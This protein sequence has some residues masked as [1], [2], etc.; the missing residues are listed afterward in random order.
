MSVSWRSYVSAHKCRSA[1]AS[2]SCATI[3]TRSPTR[4]P[5]PSRSVAT[6]S[7][8]P[9]SLRLSSRF[10]KGITDV[11]EMTFRERI[12]DSWAITSSVM[13][14]AKNSFSGSALRFRN[15]RTATEGRPGPA[16]SWFDERL[17]ERSGGPE[18]VGGDLGER[19]YDC[20]LDTCRYRRAKAA[21]R[22]HRI[23]QPLGD[24]CLRRGSGIRGLAD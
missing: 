20:L 13:P 11:R 16:G 23:G 17:G 9:I 14:S 1:D 22:G 12:F 10:L 8:A 21:H 3:R 7:L 15:G 19:L 6:S 5:L 4:R 18:P 24:Q 2:M